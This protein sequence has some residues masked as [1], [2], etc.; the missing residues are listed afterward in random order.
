[1]SAPRDRE[2]RTDQPNDVPEAKLETISDGLYHLELKNV[3]LYS[4]ILI[5]E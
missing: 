1:M 2:G 5:R 4:V 3:P